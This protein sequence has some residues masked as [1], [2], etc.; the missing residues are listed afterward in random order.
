MKEPTRPTL[1]HKAAAT[2]PDSSATQNLQ[3][4]GS[5]PV[6]FTYRCCVCFLSYTSDG[7]IHPAAGLISYSELKVTV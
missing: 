3:V 2:V 7:G 6:V 1:K 4:L 5:Q